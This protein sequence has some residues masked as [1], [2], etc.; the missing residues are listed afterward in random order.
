M[1]LL[2]RVFTNPTV[3][4][5]KRKRAVRITNAINSIEGVT[6]SENAQKLYTLWADSEITGEQVKSLLYANHNKSSVK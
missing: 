6:V 2:N 4:V 1:R 3:D 5:A